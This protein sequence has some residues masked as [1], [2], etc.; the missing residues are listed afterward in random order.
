MR[1]TEKHYV[2]GIDLAPRST[3]YAL[4]TERGPIKKHVGHITSSKNDKLELSLEKFSSQILKLIKKL[5]KAYGLSL[6]VIESTPVFTNYH[7]A[8]LM[9]AFEAVTRHVL[10]MDYG[11]RYDK[12]FVIASVHDVRRFLKLKTKQQVYDHINATF[13]MGFDKFET[14]N[15]QN[16]LTDA[17]ALGLYGL[18]ILNKKR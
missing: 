12:L 1:K 13:K 17:I 9:A 6:V 11:R 18:S 5:D 16:D 3:G 14:S 8:F 4:V 10:Y 15:R 7:T 2:L